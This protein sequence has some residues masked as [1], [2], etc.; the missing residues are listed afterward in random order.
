MDWSVM[1][2]ADNK[3]GGLVETLSNISNT[4][5]ILEQ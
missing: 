5:L 3:L 2:I 4:I 1:I